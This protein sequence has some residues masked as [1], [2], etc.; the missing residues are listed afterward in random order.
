MAAIALSQIEVQFANP[1]DQ[2]RFDEELLAEGAGV[3]R[4]WEAREECVVLGRSGC[5]ERDVNFGACREA[6]VPVLRRASGGGAVLLGP[7]CLNYAL[8]LPLIWNPAW[9]DVRY[10]L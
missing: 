9:R 1:A 10:S 2:L 3:I 4:F 8:I 5:Y 7:G 6:S